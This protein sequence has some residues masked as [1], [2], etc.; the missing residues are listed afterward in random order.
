M[1]E[2]SKITRREDVWTAAMVQYGIT[3]SSI[4]GIAAAQLSAICCLVAF[5]Y[6]SSSACFAHPS[7]PAAHR[8]ARKCITISAPHR[9]HAGTLISM[10][11]G[12]ASVASVRVAV[13]VGTFPHPLAPDIRPAFPRCRYRS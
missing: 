13:Y 12:L 5:P 7:M 9:D 3:L 2:N 8:H 4:V 10:P 6:T 11:V 1:N